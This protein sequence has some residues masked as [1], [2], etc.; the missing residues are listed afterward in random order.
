MILVTGGT[1]L[2][3]SHLLYQLTSTKQAVSAIYRDEKRIRICREIFDHYPNPEQ[4]SK[5]EWLKADLLNP[6]EVWESLANVTHIYHCAGKVSFDP[7][8]KSDLF[9]TNV[10]GT[11]NLVNAALSRKIEKMLFVSSIAAL[12][13]EDWPEYITEE[14]LRRDDEQHSDYGESKYQA[15][16]EIW[17]GIEEGLN[18]VIVNPGTILGS[19]NWHNGSSAL[20]D[21]CW[22]SFPFYTEG[23]NGIIGVHDLVDCII[24]LMESPVVQE[25]ITVV[26]KH[27]SYRELMTKIA[28]KMGKKPPGYSFP[29]MLDPLLWR[30]ALI[31]SSITRKKPVITKY[32]SK[33]ARE[34]QQFSM[35]KFNAL[36]NHSFSR[37]E[38]S[39]SQAIDYYPKRT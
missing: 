1:G 8:D 5:I 25:R 2:L 13:N 3:G 4:F 19:G 21:L 37:F 11:A 7:R 35:N 23:I 10:E 17:R 24:Q 34:K 31:A 29:K 38:E 27:F 18:A 36:M 16:L 33:I 30:L 20:F 26:D 14:S 6:E 28:Q 22:K 12:G 15:E 9:K 39:L 32:S